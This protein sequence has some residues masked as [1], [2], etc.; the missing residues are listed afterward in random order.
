M[1]IYNI[2]NPYRC[3]VSFNSVFQIKLY[4]TF[5]Y[6]IWI[7]KKS[8]WFVY[9]HS[10][11]QNSACPDERLGRARYAFPLLPLKLKS[12]QSAQVGAAA[13]P[14]EL[15]ICN[16][17]HS[18]NVPPGRDAIRRAMMTFWELGWMTSSLGSLGQPSSKT[19]QIYF[20]S[21]DADTMSSLLAPHTAAYTQGA[22]IR[23]SEDLTEV[24]QAPSLPWVSREGGH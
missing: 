7:F 8:L 19:Y 21:F 23:I 5:R 11:P 17:S 13:I 22:L 24:S 9:P 16:P 15:G 2:N 4:W 10:I 14:E 18:H 1:L 12:P 3:R 20:S 6:C